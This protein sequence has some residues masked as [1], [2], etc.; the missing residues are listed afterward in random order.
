MSLILSSPRVGEFSSERVFSA[1]ITRVGLNVAELGGLTLVLRLELDDLVGVGFLAD[2]TLR[3]EEYRGTSNLS[4]DTSSGSSGT[5]STVLGGREI[6][7]MRMTLD[8]L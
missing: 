3:N 1:A 7:D 8:R 4:G 2:S 5:T 6:L